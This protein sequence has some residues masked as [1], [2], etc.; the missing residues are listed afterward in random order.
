MD[1]QEIDEHA[2]APYNNFDN[3]THYYMEMSAL[4]DVPLEAYQK[5]GA[6]LPP[7]A[8]IHKIA[9]PFCVVHALDDPLVTW[10][11][12]AANHGLLHPSNLTNS[13]KSGNLLILLTKAGGHVGWP[14]GWF[15]FIHKWKWMNN[16][17]IT[18]VEAVQ[19]VSRQRGGTNRQCTNPDENVCENENM[20]GDGNLEPEL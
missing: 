15:P 5:Q 16:V 3:V 8:R 1:I 10:R 20:V 12:V 11:T 17:A 9:I 14:L 13:V 4:G 6:T 7:T 18:F 19:A 2:V